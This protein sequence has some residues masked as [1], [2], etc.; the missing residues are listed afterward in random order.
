MYMYVYMS[1]HVSTFE[2]ADDRISTVCDESLNRIYYVLRKQDKVQ[3]LCI[4]MLIADTSS[5]MTTLLY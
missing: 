3:L 5:V 2:R 1:I 4:G